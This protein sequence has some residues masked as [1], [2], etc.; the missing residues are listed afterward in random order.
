MSF[1]PATSTR[2]LLPLVWILP[3][4]SLCVA[5]YLVHRELKE[6][7]PRI[8]VHF[9]DGTGLVAGQ[10]KLIYK[11]L[12]MGMVREIEL[13]PDQSG[14]ALKINLHRSAASVAR[15]G[16]RF[17]IVRPEIS[18]S[19]LRAA[20]TLFTGPVITVAPGEG[21]ARRAFVGLDAAP[22]EFEASQIVSYTLRALRRGSLDAGRPITF[23][24]LQVGEVIGVELAPDASGVLIRIAIERAYAHLV[25]PASR[26]WVASG[27]DM[28]FS[29]FRGATIRTGSMNEMLGGGIAFATPDAT[30]PS[31]PAGHEFLLHDSAQD[32]WLGWAAALPVDGSVTALPSPSATPAP[33]PRGHR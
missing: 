5:G 31:P 24:D 17:W 19:G 27:L 7:G 10:T 8:T 28:S 3:L 2:R 14:V 22:P 30:E 16:S 12:P 32:E 13:L 26:F 21:K 29:L 9:S 15:E 6:R 18:L 11:G 25:R 1:V 20:E 4:V 33:R 23:R